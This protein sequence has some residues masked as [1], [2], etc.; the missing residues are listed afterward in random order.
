V[1]RTLAKRAAPTKRTR[2]YA[3]RTIQTARARGPGAINTKVHCSGPKARA[4]V[5]PEPTPPARRQENRR[6][7]IPM[8]D[9]GRSSGLRARA[10]A[11]QWED[12]PPTNHDFPDP[13]HFVGEPSVSSG[14]RSRLPLRGSPG[15][16]PGSLFAQSVGSEHQ[17]AGQSIASCNIVNRKRATPRGWPPSGNKR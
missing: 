3:T 14:V 7:F 15:I 6:G 10:V 1:C 9:A 2:Q 17:H 11:S 13:P 5:C 12:W 4:E 16:T 8:P